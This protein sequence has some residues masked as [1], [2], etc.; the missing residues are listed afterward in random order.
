VSVDDH[1][2]EAIRKSAVE[3]TPGSKA[4][5]KLRSFVIGSV[6][7]STG[8]PVVQNISCPLINTEYSAVLPAGVTSFT[9]KARAQNADLKLAFVATQSGTNYLTV[10]AG[11]S[12]TK[13]MAQLTLATTI[14]FQLNKASQTVEILQWS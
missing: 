1:G 7:I 8:S 5:Y 4:E 3:V 6:G 2:L 9:V 12:Y 11:G 13:D 14:Y 10:P